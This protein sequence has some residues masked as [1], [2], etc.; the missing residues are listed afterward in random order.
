MEVK[1]EMSFDTRSISRNVY[2]VTDVLKDVGGLSTSLL[3]GFAFL[4]M[5][6]NWN[7]DKLEFGI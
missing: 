6:L 5:G 4:V 3:S 2:G 1:Y 7:K